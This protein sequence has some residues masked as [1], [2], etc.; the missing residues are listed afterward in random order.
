MVEHVQE[1]CC[2]ECNLLRDYTA[3]FLLVNHLIYF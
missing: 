1:I 3:Q 2:A